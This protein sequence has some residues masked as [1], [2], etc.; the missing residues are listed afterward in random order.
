ML[1]TAYDQIAQVAQETSEAGV[2]SDE[3]AVVTGASKGSIAAAIAGKLLARR[4]D[5][6]A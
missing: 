2:W 4:R 1:A 6:R 3:V 5:G